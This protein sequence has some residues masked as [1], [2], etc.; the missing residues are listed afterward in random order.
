MILALNRRILDVSGRLSLLG[1][2][3]EVRQILERTGIHNIL[4]IFDTETELIKSSE[5][6]ILQTTRYNLSDLQAYPKP[7]TEFDELRSE[8]SSA[9]SKGIAQ[10]EPIQQQTFE[11]PSTSYIPPSP[12]ARPVKEE[13]FEAAYKSF[14]SE[15]AKVPLEPPPEIVRPSP[16]QPQEFIQPQM[17][18]PDLEFAP[19]Y[20]QAPPSAKRKEAGYIPPK[21]FV[22]EPPPTKGLRREEQIAAPHIA[23]AKGPEREYVDFSREEEEYTPKK[24]SFAPLFITLLIAVILI[25][26]I[27]ALFQTGLLSNLGILKGLTSKETQTPQV[28]KETAQPKPE[29]AIPEVQPKEP[30]EQ[31]EEKVEPI[32]PEPKPEPEK[33]IAMPSSKPVVKEHVERKPTPASKITSTPKYVEKPVVTKKEEPIPE[34]K[35]TQPTG[36]IIITSIP[37]GA[38]IKA[39]E[40]VIGKT[41]FEWKNPNVIGEVMLVLS[42]PGYKDAAKTI[43]YTGSTITETFRLEK[44][45]TPST[46]SA[47]ASSEEA[48]PAV[49]KPVSQPSPAPTPAPAPAPVATPSP[50][51]SASSSGGGE[52][53]TIFISS[54]PPVADVYM[55]GKLIGKTNIAKLNVLSGT[56]TMRFVKGTAEITQEMTFK[57]GDNPSKFISIK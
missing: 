23:P 54:I 10:P 26:G 9:M 2:S 24:R 46:P 53:A 51:P 5:D 30:K 36:K 1:P 34:T 6:I 44:E 28:S 20:E 40:V 15:A 13:E 21:Q 22:P 33:Q 8:I 50:T 32:K 47:S 4:K 42:K 7:K 11:Q 12:S 27:F 48:A 49:S 39:D 45:E 25:G 35:A 55:D 29:Q 56:H 38:T 18:K 31:I 52:P 41:P 17:P 16:V 43:E 57:P 14:E 19:G 3:P 37:P